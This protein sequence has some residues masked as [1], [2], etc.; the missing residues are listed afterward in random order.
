M[1]GNTEK[2]AKLDTYTVGIGIWQKKEETLK[3]LENEE[4]TLYDLEY[5]K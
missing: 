1:A 2:R 5:G 4:C 3:I